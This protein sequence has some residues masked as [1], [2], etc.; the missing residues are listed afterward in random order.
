M[1][2]KAKASEHDLREGSK[3]RCPKCSRDNLDY[4]ALPNSQAPKHM[5]I[6]KWKVVDQSSGRAVAYTKMQETAEDYACQLNANGY[7]DV[8]RR[9]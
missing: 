8:E 2:D 5:E 3:P 1:T 4:E 9:G 6:Y 7:I